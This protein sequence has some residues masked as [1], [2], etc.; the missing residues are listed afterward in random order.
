MR[1]Q[2]SS[3][4]SEQHYIALFSL[5]LLIH[6]PTYEDYGVL[7]HFLITINRLK[8]PTVDYRGINWY[9]KNHPNTDVMKSEMTFTRG[10][11][12][13]RR[14]KKKKNASN[15]VQWP[16]EV[17]ELRKKNWLLSAVIVCWSLNLPL[18]AAPKK[19]K[20]DQHE[21]R[22]LKKFNDD[23][24]LRTVKHARHRPRRTKAMRFYCS[25]FGFFPRPP[26]KM[27]VSIARLQGKI[28]VSINS[29]RSLKTRR[30]IS[31]PAL[32]RH[33]EYLST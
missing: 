20:A 10:D 32:L 2:S 31:L 4:A 24:L 30:R 5:P 8:P 15:I 6:H 7:R 16:W 21:S 28:A 13:S 19:R 29:F 14:E 11:F 22:S 26:L 27:R 17:H 12:E 3:V 23:S 25:C 18:G 9:S 33:A 1:R